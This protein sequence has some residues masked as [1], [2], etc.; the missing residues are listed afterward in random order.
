MNKKYNIIFG[1]D[2]YRALLGSEINSE[3]VS[4]VAQGF[5]QYLINEKK[6][7]K[8]SIGY[9]GRECS[10]VFAHDFACVLSANGIKVRLSDKVVPTP[11][12]SFDTKN[13]G[14][15]AGV[16]I[17]ASHNPPI[18]NGI[19]FKTNDGGPFMTQETKKVEDLLYTQAVKQDE[20]NVSLVN[21]MPQYLASLDSKVDFEAIRKAGIRPLIDSM[22]GAGCRTLEHL[23]SDKG[24]KSE[25]IFGTPEH[26]FSKRLAEPIEKNLKPL[27]DALAHGDFSLG[28]ATDGDADRLGVML[29]DGKWLSIQEVILYLSQYMISEG[30]EHPAL[31]K[32][33]SVTDK[34]KSL[35]ALVTETAVGFKYVSEAMIETGAVY[36]A[37]ESGGFGFACH[38]PERDGIFSALKFM[39]MLSKSGHKTLCSFVEEKRKQ[40]GN[41]CYD[42]IDMHNDNPARMAL[43]QELAC[44]EQ[45]SFCG[46]QIMERKQFC[47]SRG[48][49]NGLKLILKG[50][51][52]WV[53]IRVSET[54]P[55]V[56]V[57]AEA[58]SMDEVK[59]F[60][61]EGKKHFEK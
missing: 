21:M 14:C 12:L 20:K 8:V 24:I 59:A 57:Y 47:N 15:A 53:L 40:F 46:Y 52:R 19:K 42:R 16:M 3:S 54:E 25:T 31:V 38:L 51:P 27:S 35:P 23:L 10:D 6:T 34:I 11:T 37:E 41:I 45:T 1:T 58:E 32:T 2:G 61:A 13:N 48:D 49:V 36:G 9:D 4:V 29:N 56:R 18:Y 30:G 17:T 60:L 28:V 33:V 26:D 22:S 50:N 7:L 5:A 55:M 39:E 43:L 44:G